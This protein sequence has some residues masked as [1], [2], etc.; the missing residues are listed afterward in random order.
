MKRKKGLTPTEKFNF[1]G[2]LVT[3]MA[4]TRL[5]PHQLIKAKNVNIYVDGEIEVR[6][7]YT[8]VSTVA[9]GTEIDRFIHFK[10]DSY[11]KIIAYGGVYVKRLD[12]G[13]P[14]VW[15]GLSAG[16]PDTEEFRALEIAQNRLYIAAT[17]SPGVRKYVA[18]QSILW[19][20]GITKPASAITPAD[21]GTG[22]LSGT[23]YWYWTYYNSTT[24]EESDP[25]PISGVLAVTNKQVTLSNF[26][27]S[28]DPQV[29]KI[30]IY[31]NP[32]GVSTWY[33][34]GEKTND[35]NNYTDNIADN[36]L[37][38]AIS[39]RNGE[40]PKAAILKY[41][42]NRMFY[43]NADYPSRLYWSE[44]L[45][46]GSVHVNS[47]QGIED[48]DGGK[49]LALGISYDNII[50]LKNTGIFCFSFD[51]NEP[52][53]STYIPLTTEY[54]IVAPMS[55]ANLGEDLICLSSE[56][57]KIITNGGT[58]IDEI[59]IAVSGSD[60][61]RAINPIT[62]IFRECK[63]DAI[64]KAVGVYYEAKNQ[65]HISVPYYSNSNNDLTLVW[66]K[67]V[68]AFTTHEDFYVKATALYREYDNRLLYRSH[69]NQYIYQHDIG[70][71]D[72]EVDI[73]FIVQNGWNTL[74]GINDQKNIRLIFPTVFGADGV[75]L[76]YKILKDF[77]IEGPVV[78]L[79][80]QGA[81]YWGYA[82]WGQNYWGASGEV[83]YRKPN[84]I[85]GRIFSAQFYGTVNKKIGIADYQFFYQPKSL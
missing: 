61:T 79:T 22:V 77:E 5:A 54:G 63:Q 83:T 70:F 11:D 55:V 62:S 4:K 36:N 12:K 72:D 53:N 74:D 64:A 41:H 7:G 29:D 60:G 58:K 59:V 20:A 15:A 43:V 78:S 31:R 73:S 35:V 37:G 24:G 81:S 32:T 26:V 49:I 85:H 18:G 82:H 34:V 8:K 3:M 14:D 2:G 80:H 9:F 21:G 19:R 48:R 42:L 50:V 10:T 16:M 1:G 68:N 23:Y 38:P 30:R 57:L 40:P 84:F 25:S 51:V 39:I 76:N 17:D 45:L 6:G 33:Y 46:P 66:H 47:W 56:G 67:D 69:N 52:G 28:T 65:Y 44:P 27:F 75:I 71:T 13:T